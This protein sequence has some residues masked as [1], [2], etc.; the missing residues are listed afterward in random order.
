MIL[1]MKW[2]WISTGNQ[3]DQV[4]RLHLHLELCVRGR[5]AVCFVVLCS[6]SRAARR[7]A[8]VA[9]LEAE[10]LTI[11]EESAPRLRQ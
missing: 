4:R 9:A 1:E 7:L 11:W 2:K 6:V 10:F 5:I 3:T 8:W